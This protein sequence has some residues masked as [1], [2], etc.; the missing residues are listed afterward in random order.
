M[1]STAKRSPSSSM[2][3]ASNTPPELWQ[4]SVFRKEFGDNWNGSQFS[5]SL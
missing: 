4:L 5:S 1:T 2:R 3:E